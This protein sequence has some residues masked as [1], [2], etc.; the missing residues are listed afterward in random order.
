MMNEKKTTVHVTVQGSTFLEVTL[1]DYL[2]RWILF[3][4]SL[5]MN[6]E[7]CWFCFFLVDDL[8][9][10]CSLSL[11]HPLFLLLLLPLLL[12]LLSL[13][14][15]QFYLYRL[16][17]TLYSFYCFNYSLDL[18]IICCLVF[19]FFLLSLSN[20]HR[21]LSINWQLLYSYPLIH[22]K[23]IFLFTFHVTCTLLTRPVICFL[24]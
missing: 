5:C 21:F 10:F 24:L 2:T 23:N 6:R 13:P 18:S 12:L 8:H 15:R 14:P 17:N 22:S 20:L 4:Y 19:I 11:S 3:T 1:H 16:W 7:S 9:L